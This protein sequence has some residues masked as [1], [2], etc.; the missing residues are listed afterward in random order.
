VLVVDDE[1]RIRLA[2]RACLEAEHYEVE[3][4]ADGI[5]ALAAVRR[6]TPRLIILD[7]AMPGL[8]GHATLAELV[9]I[10]GDSMPK[11]IVLTAYGS[12]QGSAVLLQRGAAAVLEKPLLPDMLRRTIEQVLQEGIIR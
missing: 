4:A 12:P 11:V 7:L 9:R 6:C 10:M 1:S 2:L 3:E 8:S 5:Q